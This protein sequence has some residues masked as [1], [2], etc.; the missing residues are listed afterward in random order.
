LQ[1]KRVDLLGNSK[2][3]LPLVLLPEVGISISE[4]PNPL[5]ETN[6]ED[7]ENRMMIEIAENIIQRGKPRV[8]QQ[9]PN[10]FCSPHGKSFDRDPQFGHF[11]PKWDNSRSTNSWG[12]E[13]ANPFEETQRSEDAPKIDFEK[14]F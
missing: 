5:E 6:Q 11:K 10:V 13:D 3:L 4:T 9:Y 2:H 1:R 8:S 7:G 14:V 12:S